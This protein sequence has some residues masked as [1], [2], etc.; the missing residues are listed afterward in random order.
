ML[1]GE[2]SVS[3]SHREFIRGVKLRGRECREEQKGLIAIS[4]ALVELFNAEGF[5]T[6]S[7]FILTLAL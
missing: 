2:F 6:N 1:D 3:N 7:Y 5:L 4:H